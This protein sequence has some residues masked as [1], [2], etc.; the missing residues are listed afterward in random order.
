VSNTTSHLSA[1]AWSRGY[2]ARRAQPDFH[3]S[4]VYLHWDPKSATQ[5]VGT[6]NCAPKLNTRVPIDPC[7][8]DC[9]TCTR[10]RAR[11]CQT[12][13]RIL[14][15][16]RIEEI[17]VCRILTPSDNSNNLNERKRS[18]HSRISGYDPALAGIANHDSSR[19]QLPRRGYS[20]KNG[21]T[22]AFYLADQQIG[23]RD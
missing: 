16:A 11:I 15:K 9:A 5:P 8:S 23:F 21:V 4:E 14:W 12:R 7:R 6:G 18:A 3:L 13:A 19:Q 1:S 17:Q 22:A 2:K 10:V 20:T